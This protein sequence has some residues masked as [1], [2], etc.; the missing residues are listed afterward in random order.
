MTHINDLMDP[1]L[2][3]DMIE[4]G[5]IR[6]RHHPTLPYRILGYTETAQYS[7]TWNEATLQCR[8]LVLDNADVVIAR[9]FAKFFN[10]SEHDGSRLPVLDL[11]APVEVTDKM[12]GSLG[13]LVPTPDGHI[14]ATRGS[15]ESE[16][17]AWATRF[18]REHYADHFAGLR[19]ITILFEIIFKANRI[20]VDY[21]FEDLVLLGGI[22]IDTGHLISADLIDWPGHKAHEFPYDTLAEALAAP[23]RDNAEGFV[24]R[25]LDESELMVKIKLE[26]YLQLHKIITGLSEKSVWEHASAGLAF[27]D[28]IADL[29]DEFHDWVTN[30]WDDLQECRA[31]I[32]CEARE[33]FDQ[34][35]D[36]LPANGS[37]KEFALAVQE[38]PK[39]GIRPFL[40]MLLDGNIVKLDAAI[41]RS[42]KPVGETYMVNSE[43]AA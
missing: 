4:Q 26:R 11:K 18:Y 40:F 19:D 29:P 16:Q 30:V 27:E 10:D 43:E 5:F 12:D 13:I 14:I 7:K 28:L 38:Y 32:G 36:Y 15:F 22:E 21:D 37:R 20:V 8:G 35:M 17:A 42:L 3:A 23:V 25:Y 31:S 24:V 1:S 33:I 9:P 6:E 2:L 39:P 41:W 34:L